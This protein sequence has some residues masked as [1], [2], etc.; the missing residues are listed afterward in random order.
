MF[1]RERRVTRLGE[2]RW[3]TPPIIEWQH[4][5]ARIAG[6]LTADTDSLPR[7][8]NVDEFGDF[9]WQD[10]GTPYFVENGRIRWLMHECYREEWQCDH[11]P[12]AYRPGDAN[13]K[14]QY[15]AAIKRWLL[16]PQTRTADLERAF[17]W[18]IHSV[19]DVE[20]E[21]VRAIM[22]IRTWRRRIRTNTALTEAER[23]DELSETYGMFNY[24]L[25]NA[26]LHVLAGMSDNNFM[27]VRDCLELPSFRGGYAGYLPEY[28]LQVLFTKVQVLTD[29]RLCCGRLIGPPQARNTG[30][31]G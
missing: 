23:Q 31:N 6:A 1:P 7:F 21:F 26:L 14:P 22:D 10:P 8:Y 20:P 18:A 30:V 11:L 19:A 5:A 13:D 9:L 17:Y 29:L 25:N 15:V 28:L 2:R 16:D 27:A 24:A 12:E 4:A 3:D